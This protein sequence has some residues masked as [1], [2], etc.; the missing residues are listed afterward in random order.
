[1]FIWLKVTDYASFKKT[2]AN[3]WSY[4][5]YGGF[6]AIYLMFGLTYSSYALT[7]EW[8]FACLSND[9]SVLAQYAGFVRGLGSLGMMISFI[10]AEQI[11]PTWAQVTVQ[12]M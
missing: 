4:T 5:H 3:D 7:V 1:M 6:M 10:L 12:L 8:V 9:P 11:V 2:P